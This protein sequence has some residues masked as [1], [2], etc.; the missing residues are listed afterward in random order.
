MVSLAWPAPSAWPGSSGSCALQCDTKN[1][2]AH[3]LL[4]FAPQSDPLLG[5]HPDALTP[6][7]R[8]PFVPGLCDHPHPY[9]WAPFIAIGKDE[10]VQPINGGNG[11]QLKAPDLT[12]EVKK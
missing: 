11:R 6:S 3:P 8:T 2:L 9:S 1:P 5:A 7:L 4:W 12:R 10:A